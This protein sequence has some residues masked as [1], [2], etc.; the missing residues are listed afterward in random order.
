MFS[1][2]CGPFKHF[3][4]TSQYFFFC[5]DILCSWSKPMQCCN[6]GISYAPPQIHTKGNVFTFAFAV[7]IDVIAFYNICH[8]S[9]LNILGGM[10]SYS[11]MQSQHEAKSRICTATFW[12]GTSDSWEESD[13]YIWTQL[14]TITKFNRNIVCTFIFSDFLQNHR[15]FN[16]NILIKI[17]FKKT[18]NKL[19]PVNTL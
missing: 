6:N 2:D 10:E 9:F 13:R 8:L 14:L 16:I 17:L 3:R 11:E 4:F 1:Y 12:L 7:R 15:L 19:F 5:S 18:I